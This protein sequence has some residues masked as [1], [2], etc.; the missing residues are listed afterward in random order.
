MI[1]VAKR[2]L[3]HLGINPERL[4]LE[5]VSASEGARLAEVVTAFTEK[6]KES[7]PL[8]ADS[9]KGKEVLDF[10]LHAA[11]ETVS[12]EKLRWVA[13]KQTE[14]RTDGNKYGEVFTSHEI[15]RCLDGVI[16]EEIT[17]QQI[18]ALLRQE[19]I[20]VKELSKRLELKPPVVFRHVLALK[21]KELVKLS[22]IRGRS[23]LY[24]AIERQ[25][26]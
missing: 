4:L 18:L 7:G 17:A 22:E 24:M 9:P 23:P 26:S 12:G 20:S 19:S 21:R 6:I 16:L 10:K 2:I 3:I 25:P 5:W 1:N 8:A 13:A 14:F 11:L 15:G